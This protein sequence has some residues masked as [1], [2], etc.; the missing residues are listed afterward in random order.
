MGFWSNPLQVI[1]D[2]L[3][4]LLTGWGLPESLA[5]VL[6][7]FVGIVVLLSVVMILDI[8]LVWLE[9]KIVSR[10]QDR[11]GPNRVGPFGLI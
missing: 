4:G 7:V 6:I 11:I 9:R 10:F 1:N 5:H 3:T 2:W 8:F